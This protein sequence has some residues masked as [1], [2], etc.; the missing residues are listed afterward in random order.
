LSAAAQESSSL[1]FATAGGHR[2]HYELVGPGL[3]AAP[4]LVLLHHALGSV[5]TWGDFPARLVEATGLGALVY[6]RWGHGRSDPIPPTP[7]PPD[8][9]DYEAWTVLPELL[10]A[11]G[12]RETILIG[13]SDGGTIAIYH[14]ARPRPVPV[15]GLITMAA[16]I[17][18]DQHSFDGMRRGRE[19]WLKGATAAGLARYHGDKTE[20]I[21]RSWSGRWLDPKALG[22]NA[23]HVLPAITCPALIMQGSEDEFGTPE[24]VHAIVRGISGPAEGVILDGIGHEPQREAPERIVE[25][26]AHFI[27]ECCAAPAADS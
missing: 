14:A 23:E 26:M 1:P 21:Y 25:A 6:S 10:A 17:F 12:L 3:E 5:E 13:H 11:A 15:R 22:W 24:Q 7:R 9:F 19:D 2:L 18:Y 27:A 8:Y 16:H 20:A 4:T